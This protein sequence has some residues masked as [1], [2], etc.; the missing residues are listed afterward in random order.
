[1]EKFA[2][3]IASL[4]L[5]SCAWAEPVHK[6]DAV[7]DQNWMLVSQDSKPA[8]YA[9]TTL[10]IT[11]DGKVS[12]RAPV[13]SYGGQ[14]TLDGQGGC[15]WGNGFIATRMAGAPELMDAEQKY[16]EALPKTAKVDLSNGVLTFSTADGQTKVVFH[17]APSEKRQ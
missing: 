5:C 17:Q 13:N 4:L 11:N 7:A 3:R 14:I 10:R 2:A 1:M 16:F 15:K 9:K 8:A 6:L 12:G